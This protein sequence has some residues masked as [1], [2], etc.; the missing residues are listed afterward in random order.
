ML[1]I[2]FV[3]SNGLNN[4]FSRFPPHPANPQLVIYVP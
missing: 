3:C 1:R 4:S 2:R